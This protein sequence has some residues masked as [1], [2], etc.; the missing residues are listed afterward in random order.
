MYQHLTVI[1]KYLRLRHKAQIMSVDINYRQVPGLRIIKGAHHLLHAVCII[2]ARRWRSHQLT[3]SKPVIQLLPEHDVAYIV[4]QKDAQQAM[5]CVKY[6]KDVAMCM[7]NNTDQ[8]TQ[9]HIGTYWGKV[10]LH[11]ILHFHQRQNRLVFVMRKQLAFLGQTHGINTMRLKYDDC[12]VGTDG[13]NHQRQEQVVTTSQF[14]NEKYTCQRGMHYSAHHTGHTHQ[15]KI[16][17]GQKRGN[18]ESVAEMGKH[19]TG[20]TPQIKRR[21]KDSTAPSAAISGTGSKDLE[22][23]D[24][25]KVEQQKIAVPI[26]ERIVHHRVPIGYAHAPSIMTE[27]MRPSSK[28]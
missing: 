19:K 23:D 28:V 3:H 20:D 22:S 17:L 18:I 25:Q 16:L 24:K 14:S 11:H 5:V 26:E 9:I 12:Q 21:S 6:R 10:C 27:G 1:I 4:Q 8:S 13:N 2:E 7:R 15:R